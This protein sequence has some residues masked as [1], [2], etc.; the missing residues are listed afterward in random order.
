MRQWKGGEVTSTAALSAASRHRPGSRLRHRHCS[1][2]IHPS[3]DISMLASARMPCPQYTCTYPGGRSCRGRGLSHSRASTRSPA[4]ARP[5]AP[6]SRSQ[7][8]RRSYTRRTAAGQAVSRSEWKLGRRSLPSHSLQS[9]SSRICRTGL[10]RSR[11]LG[12]SVMGQGKSKLSHDD[13]VQLQKQTYFNRRELNQ[14]AHSAV[15]MSAIVPCCVVVDVDCD[16][17]ESSS[18]ILDGTRVS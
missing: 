13:L 9:R 18:R 7:A 1:A 6:P 3:A 14:Y 15:P 12:S 16:P 11:V 17:C 8:G 5:A 4:N 10:R 2:S